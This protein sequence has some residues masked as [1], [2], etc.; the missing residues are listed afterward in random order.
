MGKKVIIIGSG[1]GGLSSGVF[2]AKAGYDVTILEQ[3]ARIGGCLQCFMRK[4]V[5]FETGMHFIGSVDKGQ[6]LYKLINALEI[7]DKIQLSRLDTDGYDVISLWGNKYKFA[8]GRR[9]FIDQMTEYFPNQRNNLEHYW[10]L[11]ETVANSSSVHTLQLNEANTVAGIEYQMRPIDEVIDSV[12][13]DSKLA[14]VL[15]GNLPLYAGERGK[16]PFST[17]AFIMDFY[18]QS[19]FRVVGGSDS[20]AKALQD[21]LE[22]YGGRVW[23]NKKVAKIVCDD[24]RATG[25]VCTDGSSYGADIIISSPHPLRTLEMLDD[26]PLI[27]HAYRERLRSISQTIG[28]FALYLHFKENKVPYMNSNYYAYTQ[29]SSWNCESYTWENWPKGYLYMHFCHEPFPKFA[30]AGVVLSYMRM[31]DVKPWVGTKTGR[32]GADY[33]YFKRRHAEKLIACLEKE[34]PGLSDEIEDYYTSTPL[35]YIDYTGTEGGSIYGIARDVSKG[36]GGRVSHRTRIPNVFLTGQNVNSH[37]MLGTLVGS[38]ITC[39]ELI[40]EQRLYDYIA[41][42]LNNTI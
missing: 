24:M 36:A 40:G 9:A 8:N 16:T 31:D 28:G 29:E 20:I 6:A 42:P 30:K 34:F 26:T 22:K 1:L 4:G 11:V 10:D 35:T 25:V 2:L 3:S 5:K 17:H 37:G 7:K 21:V 23:L 18:N 13:T 14:E 19:S 33:E 39:S 12:I 38:V 32:R 27:R 15:V 41:N